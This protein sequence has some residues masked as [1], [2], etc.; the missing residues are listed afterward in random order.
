MSAN[1]LRIATA[2]LA[3]MICSPAH[4]K[5][6][7]ASGVPNDVA[8]DGVALGEAHDYETRDVAEARALQECRTNKDS[9]DSVHALC[10]IV[11]H[12][13][14]RCFATALDPKAGTPGWGWA[15]ADTSNEASDHA[16][17]MCHVSAGD[18]APYCVITQTACDGTAK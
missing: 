11:D 18:R 10:K 2:M 14:N 7:F 15:I 6:A 16:L 3:L 5:S 1:S 4:A 8:S 9:A 17:S 12:F 13:D